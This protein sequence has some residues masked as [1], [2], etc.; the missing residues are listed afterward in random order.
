[1]HNDFCVRKFVCKNTVKSGKE[2]NKKEFIYPYKKMFIR[3]YCC[4]FTERI[5]MLNVYYEFTGLVW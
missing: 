2:L 1:M 4:M 3:V 5:G